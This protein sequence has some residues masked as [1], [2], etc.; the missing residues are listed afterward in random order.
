MWERSQKADQ[1]YVC[2]MENFLRRIQEKSAG[3]GIHSEDIDFSQ[4][5]T[6]GRDPFAFSKKAKT[7]EGIES[8]GGPLHSPSKI[9][10]GSRCPESPDINFSR[11]RRGGIDEPRQNRREAAGRFMLSH[12]FQGEAGSSLSGKPGD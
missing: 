7:R 8:V 11:R 6:L 2:R 4:Q 1:Q 9:E 10:L 12:V 5:N 3:L